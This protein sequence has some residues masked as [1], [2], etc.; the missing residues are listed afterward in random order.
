MELLTQAGRAALLA[1]FDV[2]HDA[3]LDWFQID[4]ETNTACATLVLQAQDA[5]S[6]SGWSDVV[7]RVEGVRR[8]RLTRPDMLSV[9]SFGLQFL[10]RDG[11][12]HLFLNSLHSGPDDWPAAQDAVGELV[13]GRCLWRA[14]PIGSQSAPSPVLR[15]ADGRAQALVGWTSMSAPLDAA[16]GGRLRT[17]S[18]EAR[19]FT[20]LA[21]NPGQVLSLLV[22]VPGGAQ[23]AGQPL[24]VRAEVQ[25]LLDFDIEIE[26]LPR[27]LLFDHLERD[28]VAD[29]PHGLVPRVCARWRATAPEATA[30]GGRLEAFGRTLSVV[31]LGP[32]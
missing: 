4:F 14:S 27:E 30:G 25:D 2:F 17:L 12:F 15:G 19:L 9:I 18:L 5:S 21:Q 29:R 13:G 6:P 3:V 32:P 11:S 28:E 23:A 16:T 31:G 22:E 8:V 20:R 1:R 24:W 7:L 26:G 10:W